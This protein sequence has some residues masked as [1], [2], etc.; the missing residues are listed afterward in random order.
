MPAGRLHPRVTRGNAA[1]RRD[2]PL[3]YG[4]APRSGHAPAARPGRPRAGPAPTEDT[5]PSRGPRPPPTLGAI[6]TPMLIPT[7]SRSRP[8]SRSPRSCPARGPPGPSAGCFPGDVPAAV[9]LP[10][11]GRAGGQRCS[12]AVTHTAWQTPHRAPTAALT[13]HPLGD[14]RLIPAPASTSPPAPRHP[15][16]RA[17]P[18]DMHRCLQQHCVPHLCPFPTTPGTVLPHPAR[19]ARPH[20]RAVPAPQPCLGSAVTQDELPASF[21]SLSPLVPPAV[22]VTASFMPQSRAIQ[23]L[24]PH[25]GPKGTA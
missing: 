23:L 3:Y 18:G 17:S 20:C 1:A 12:S 25:S 11:P 22:P 24:Q 4:H 15:P 19:S 21:C 2:T 6:P 10:Q 16:L 14:T 9:G 13:Q 5:P 7:R 8:R